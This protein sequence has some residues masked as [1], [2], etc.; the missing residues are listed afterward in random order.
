MLIVEDDPLV[1]ACMESTLLRKGYRILTAADGAEAME[2]AASSHVDIL[3]TDVIM[4]V[5][6]GMELFSSLK[7]IQPDMKVLFVSGYPSDILS[8]K[9][10]AGHRFLQ[11]PLKRENLLAE[12]RDILDSAERP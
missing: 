4:P 7:K 8:A 1:R 10:M 9:G 3:V 6:N 5:M 2:A 12:I 11:K